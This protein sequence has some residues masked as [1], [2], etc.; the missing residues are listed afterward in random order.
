MSWSW[1]R[2]SSPVIFLFLRRL[3]FLVSSI[4]SIPLNQASKSL[5]CVWNWID[6]WS[7]LIILFAKSRRLW[8]W[9][10]SGLSM[11]S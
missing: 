4:S 7:T 5:R 11:L 9:M 3:I 1:L 8:A 2:R 6:A 10:F